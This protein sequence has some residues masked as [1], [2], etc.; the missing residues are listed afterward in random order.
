MIRALTFTAC[1]MASAALAQPHNSHSQHDG[2][3]TQGRQVAVSRGNVAEAPVQA[4][5]SAFAA[6]QEIVAILEADR[7]T[8]WAKVDIGALRQHLIDMSNVTLSA[9]VKNES[10]EGGIRFIVTGASDVR[11]SV[12]RMIFAHAVTMSGQDGWGFEASEIDGGAALVV[13]PPA[14]DA[15]KLRGLG[16]IGIMTR[17]MHHQNHHLMI[18]R[19]QHPH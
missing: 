5:Q 17:G 9:D 14:Q 8:D 18:A 11:E 12:R 2:Q 3:Q 7:S 10:T 4:G 19:G 1:L 6:I 16:F 15:G 13:R